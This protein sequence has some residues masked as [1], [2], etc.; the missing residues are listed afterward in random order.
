MTQNDEK[1]TL[2]IAAESAQRLIRQLEEK[3]A[4]YNAKIEA[5]IQPLIRM[6]EA[7]ES[8]SGKKSKT[9]FLSTKSKGTRQ[10]VRRGQVDNHIFTVLWEDKILS[11]PDIRE[12]VNARFGC[13]YPRSTIY[14]ALVRG[15]GK[16]K[17]I[18]QHTKWRINPK[19]KISA[20]F[21]IPIESYKH[22]TLNPN[23]TEQS[24]S[25]ENEMGRSELQLQAA[26]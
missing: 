22:I 5:K 20:E 15:Q 18:E 4:T 9:V 26:H 2:R 23:E 7:W 24:E 3:R 11:E 13:S 25:E 17:Y 8:F 21:T 6:V 12:A 19:S 16:G 10:R 1:E 14:S